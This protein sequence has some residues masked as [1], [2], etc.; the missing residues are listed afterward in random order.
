MASDTKNVAKPSGPTEEPLT[1]GHRAGVG[2]AAGAAAGAATVYQVAVYTGDVPDAGTDANV[3]LWVDGTAGRSGWR[4]LDNADDNFER[5]RTD[6]FYLN[7]PDLGLLSAAWLFFSRS[8][9]KPGWFLNTVVVNGKT[10]SYYNWIEAT[11]MYRL[12]ST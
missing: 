6:Y 1:R 12:T 7:L 2:A 4:F 5:G 3:W 11:G 10:F 8:G 9:N